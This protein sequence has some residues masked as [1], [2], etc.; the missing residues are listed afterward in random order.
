MLV[1]N[2]PAHPNIQSLRSVTLVFL[3]ANTTSTTQPMDCGVIWS[4]KTHYRKQLMK[5]LLISHDAKLPFQPNLMIALHWL[6]NAW[7]SV[8][9]ETIV[10]C[11]NK[12][13]L[14]GNASSSAVIPSLTPLVDSDIGN[15]FDR[16]RLQF[17]LSDISLQAYTSIDENIICAEMPSESEILNSLTTTS[18]IDIT[19]SDHSDDE[20]SCDTDTHT[21]TPTD[22]LQMLHQIH[23][24]LLKHSSSVDDFNSL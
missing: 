10:N 4:L 24:C 22:A 1:D 21:P 13:G 15:I 19:E 5:E 3:P 16:M 7:N 20:S 17:S 18:T 8:T 6:R 14:R 23:L 2:C 12:A 9:K 11:F